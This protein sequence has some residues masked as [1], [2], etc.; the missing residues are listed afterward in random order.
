M[1]ETVKKKNLWKIILGIIMIVIGVL[2]FVGRVAINLSYNWSILNVTDEWGSWIT[3]VLILG[4]QIATIVGGILLIMDLDM[5]WI[6]TIFISIVLALVLFFI[7]KFVAPDVWE[8]VDDKT[9]ESEYFGIRFECPEGWQMRDEKSIKDM[10]YDENVK[11][12]MM[13]DH[14]SGA[15]VMVLIG[16]A[17]SKE[18]AVSDI[19][20]KLSAH[21]EKVGNMEFE[22]DGTAEILEETTEEILGEKYTVLKTRVLYE[23]DGVVIPIIQKYRIAAR[24]GKAICIVET[25]GETMDE[26]LADK[27][28]LMFQKY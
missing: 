18:R 10:S 3:T 27:T 5:W 16:S 13:A 1:E 15:N 21:T 11:C 20:N 26:E 9:W 6:L 22:V 23:G 4:G 25:Y 8:M 14:S 17:L 19:K 7:G 2:S 12:R 28:M 24:A